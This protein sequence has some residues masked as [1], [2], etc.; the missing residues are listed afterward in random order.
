MR[1]ACFVLETVQRIGC[2]RARVQAGFSV[3]CVAEVIR[4]LSRREAKRRI[5]HQ[6]AAISVP[7]AVF[8]VHEDA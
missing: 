5:E 3:A 7:E 1:Q 4:R 8:G 2:D 6:G